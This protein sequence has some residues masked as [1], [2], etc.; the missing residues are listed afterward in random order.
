MSSA[1]LSSS[2]RLALRKQQLLVESAALR[3]LWSREVGHLRQPL[4]WVDRA[5]IGMAWASRRPGWL[6]AGLA[7]AGGALALI[8]PARLRR[9][10][11]LAVGGWRLW[12]RYGGVVQAVL[13]GLLG[14]GQPAGAADAPVTFPEAHREG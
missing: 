12:Q 4:G 5:A 3:E 13:P 9:W 6:L 14:R 10:S 2:A 11:G 1:P 8:G 7:A